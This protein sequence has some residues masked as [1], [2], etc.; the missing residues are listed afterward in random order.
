MNKILTYTFV[1]FGIFLC[2]C[3]QEEEICN[4]EAIE[5]VEAIEMIN[6]TKIERREW[7][8]GT[9]EVKEYVD[10]VTVSDTTRSSSDFLFILDLYEDGTGK[11]DLVYAEYTFSLNWMYDY[12]DNQDRFAFFFQSSTPPLA[13]NPMQIGI[14]KPLKF[15]EDSQK[16]L[17]TTPSFAEDEK[18]YLNQME[19]EKLQ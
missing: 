19:F 6:T 14:Y 9:W 17:R 7:M 15:S 12:V 4:I 8:V 2:S 1:L 10:L 18:W 13:F 11:I 5:E 3:E 16:W